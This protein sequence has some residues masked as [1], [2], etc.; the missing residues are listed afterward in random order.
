MINESVLSQA[1]DRLVAVAKPARVILFGSYA[2]G[3]ATVDSDLDFMVIDATLT[4]TLR[5]RAVLRKAVG[6]VGTGV[7]VLV[8]SQEEADRRGQVPGT[9]IYWALKEGRVMY[10]SPTH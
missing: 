8:V 7:D 5:D 9:I 2:T 6:D 4:G 3:D 10:E 1:V